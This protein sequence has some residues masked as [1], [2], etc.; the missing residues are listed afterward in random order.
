[1]SAAPSIFKPFKHPETE[2]S[3]MD[4]GL[5]YNNPVKIANHERRLLW[6]DVAERHPDI[7]L[8]IGTG[9]NLQETE[10]EMEYGTKSKS[11]A[12]KR[13]DAKPYGKLGAKELKKLKSRRLRLFNTVKNVKNFFSILVSLLS[14][15]PHPRSIY[16]FVCMFSRS[17]QKLVGETKY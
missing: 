14:V 12:E 8:S 11:D 13:K 17:L 2:R 9:Q 10:A 16:I 15:M 1:M 5:Y 7:M 6:S 4:G 3:Y